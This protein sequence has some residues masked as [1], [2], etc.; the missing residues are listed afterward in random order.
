MG[1][2]PDQIKVLQQLSDEGYAVCIWTPEE[3]QGVPPHKVEDNC[4]ELG[5]HVIEDLKD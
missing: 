5:Y 3:L 1:M 2:I 4:A